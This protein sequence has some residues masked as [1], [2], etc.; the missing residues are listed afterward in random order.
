MRIERG[1][2][3]DSKLEQ[4]VQLLHNHI[5]YALSDPKRVLLLYMLADGPKRVSELVEVLS[6]PQSTVSR[7]LR[8]LRERGLADTER[9]GTAVYYALADPR[10]IQALDLLRAILVSQLEASAEWV[11]S[12]NLKD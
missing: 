7:H 8:V 4:E 2:M 6:L 3:I 1:L 10:I 9:R 12:L 11:H 5:C